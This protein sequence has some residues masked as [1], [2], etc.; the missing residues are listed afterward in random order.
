[1][2]FIEIDLLGWLCAAIA[3][4]LCTATSIIILLARSARRLERLLIAL[5][6]ERVDNLEVDQHRHPDPRIEANLCFCRAELFNLL[7]P[8]RISQLRQWGRRFAFK[9]KM[10]VNLR[11]HWRIWR[12]PLV[13]P[14]P[15][16]IATDI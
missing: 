3:V 6:K 14:D 13:A 11:L 8:T 5:L 1:L 4:V 10:I 16:E 9:L 2:I 15:T 12:R 7:E